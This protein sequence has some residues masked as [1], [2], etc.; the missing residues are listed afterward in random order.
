MRPKDNR[1]YFNDE[2]NHVPIKKIKRIKDEFKRNK[3]KNIGN[4]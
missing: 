4:L 2:W 3:I 1:T